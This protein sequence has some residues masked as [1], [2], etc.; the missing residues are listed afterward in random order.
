MTSKSNR[1]SFHRLDLLPHV[2]LDLYNNNVAI[3]MHCNLRSPNVSPAV[4]SPSTRSIPSF[5]SVNLSVLSYSVVTDETL[6]Y[7][8]HMT[9]IAALHTGFR[10]IPTSMT[11]NHLER[12][13]SPY[14]AFFSP[15]SIALLADYVTVV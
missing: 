13:N 2:S 9:I 14:F 1:F 12:C 3:A 4:C 11:L 8:K 10:L 15:N 6:R 7:D 5:Q